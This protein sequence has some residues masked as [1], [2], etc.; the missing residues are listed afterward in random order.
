MLIF[1]MFFEDLPGSLGDS[2]GNARKFCYLNAIAPIR[3]PRLNGSEEN[4]PVLRL[5]HCDMVI[6]D[7]GQE[8]RKFCDL[9]VM[10]RKDSL[11]MKMR[12]DIF[13]DCPGQRQAVKRRRST[14][15]LI[16]N[17]QALRRGGIQYDRGLRHLNHESGSAPRE[18]IRGADARENSVNDGK[19]HQLRWNE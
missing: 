3:R 18:I 17:D 19:P 9:V 1:L 15:D 6:L 4:D 7:A 2:G 16:Q 8:I 5:L 14:A 10:G 13:D 11:C 12:L